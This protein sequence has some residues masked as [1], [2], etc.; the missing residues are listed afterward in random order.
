MTASR[1]VVEL[2]DTPSDEPLLQVTAVPALVQVYQVLPAA[3]SLILIVLPATGA[4][5]SVKVTES[6]LVGVMAFRL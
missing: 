4:E 1:L 3:T 6:I 5:S 2:T